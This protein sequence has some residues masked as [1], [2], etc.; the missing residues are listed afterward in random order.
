M[1]AVYNGSATQ[2]GK[3]LGGGLYVWRSALGVTAN[4]ALVYVG[5][6]GLDIADLATIMAH[7]GAVRAME[8]D[9]N[10]DWVNFSTYQPATVDGAANGLNGTQL[11]TGMTGTPARYF[12]SWWSRDF[13]TMSAVPATTAPATTKPSGRT[14]TTTRG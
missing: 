5:G 7:A 11:L 13:I 6:P 12:Q 14:T 1:P 9:I 3:T 10:T 8:M 4:G 2:W